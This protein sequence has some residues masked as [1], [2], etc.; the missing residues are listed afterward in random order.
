MNSNER[1]VAPRMNLRIPLRFRPITIPTLPEQRAETLNVSQNGVFFATDYP[2]TVGTPVE[3]LLKM[4][5]ELTGKDSTE[6]RCKAR[7]VHVQP[8]G[9][10]NNKAGVGAHIE[11]YEAVSTGDRW[12]S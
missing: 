10:A 8:D 5:R 1:R 3:L 12:A 6:V 2:L 11:R 7:V 9:F 4:P